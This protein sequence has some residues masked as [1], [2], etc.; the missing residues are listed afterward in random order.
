MKISC[1]SRFHKYSYTLSTYFERCGKES[2][3]T[4]VI[5]GFDR[6]GHDQQQWNETIKSQKKK[7]K[8]AN[9]NIQ[10]RGTWTDRQIFLK[11]N[12]NTFLKGLI[13]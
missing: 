8:S 13:E 7:G 4:T 1:F 10:L 9:S 2:D 3:F 12:I 11:N 5:T 6:I